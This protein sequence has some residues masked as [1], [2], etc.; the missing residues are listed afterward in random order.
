MLYGTGGLLYCFLELQK[1]FGS[2][3]IKD[4]RVDLKQEIYTLSRFLYF[5]AINKTIGVFTIVIFDEEYLGAA[6]GLFGVLYVMMKA[7]ELTSEYLKVKDPEF[8]ISLLEA[9]IKSM[10]FGLGLQFPSG[11]FSSSTDINEKDELLQY[12]HGSPGIIPVL[13]FGYSFFMDIKPELSEKIKI[14]AIKAGED[15]WK[16]GLL[17]KGLIYVMVYLGMHML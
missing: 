5:K 9:L 7:Y 1:N 12:C 2:C 4:F 11:N 6:H 16:R 3:E 17:K 15:L 8:E 14:A 10:E 13:T